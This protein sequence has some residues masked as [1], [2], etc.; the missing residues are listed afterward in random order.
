MGI[1]QIKK[2]VLLEKI[3][4]L[5][6]EN[7]ELRN[8]LKPVG[9][10]PQDVV[11][12]FEFLVAITDS[13]PG[14]IA[15]VDLESL[16]YQFVNSAFEKSF[17]KPASQIVGMHIKDLIGEENYQFALKYI[18]I[19]KKGESVSYENIFNISTGRRWIKVNYVPYFDN[20]GN[21]QS[22][23]VLSY[24]ITEKKLAE[25]ELK[26]SERELIIANATKDKFLSII[27]HDLRNPFNTIK[28]FSNL[29]IENFESYD[30]SKIIHFLNAVNVSSSNAYELLDDLLEW[31]RSHTGKID[32]K[33]ENYNLK[34]LVESAT[35]FQANQF[36]SKNIGYNLNLSPDILVYIDKNMINT[37][38]RNLLTNA[39]KFT[40]EGGSVTISAKVEGERVTVKVK[41]TGVGMTDEVLA[42][43]FKIDELANTPGT[44][45]EKGTGL[46]LI[47]CKEFIDKH[48]GK[49]WAEGKPGE[50]S[51]FYFTLPAFKG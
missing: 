32:Y 6:K 39:V 4:K 5:Q 21:V 29:L 42:N 46:G 11:N 37:V 40:K 28:G 2:Q 13:M 48:N 41:D 3:E 17:N 44:N 49:I 1:D 20:F 23:I 47:I 25:E 16:K 36:E 31:A 38:L 27:A 15:M 24:D 45:D 18:A 26:K 35:K 7:A 33:P 30:K 34:L 43:L 12:S 10:D 51:S 14:H 19:V 22:I 50:G 9:H 8:L